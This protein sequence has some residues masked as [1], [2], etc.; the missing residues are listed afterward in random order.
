[1]QPRRV[2]AETAVVGLSGVDANLAAAV[3]GLTNLVSLVDRTDGGL[4]TRNEQPIRP[5]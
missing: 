2:E 4:T 1:M 5:N 3:V